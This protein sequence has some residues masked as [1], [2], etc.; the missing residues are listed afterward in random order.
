LV[1]LS[2]SLLAI[3]TLASMISCGIGPEGPNLTPSDLTVEFTGDSSKVCDLASLF[4]AGAPG[5]PASSADGSTDGP[6]DICEVTAS[7]TPSSDVDFCSY[8]LYRAESPDISSD[9]A[10]ATILGEF[11]NRDSTVYADTDVG[12]ATHYYYAVRTTD[13]NNDGVWSNEALIVTPGSAPTPSVLSEAYS[14]WDL[15]D[16]IWTSCPDSDFLV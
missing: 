11:A 15:V 4:I 3:A 13:I 16:L 6:L 8:V 5:L 9:P 14:S 1:R 2:G 10:S 7:W 12:W